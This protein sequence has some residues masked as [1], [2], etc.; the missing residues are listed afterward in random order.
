MTGVTR[1]KFYPEYG[2]AMHSRSARI[3]SLT[4]GSV[5]RIANQFALPFQA[6]SEHGKPSLSHMTHRLLCLLLVSLMLANQGLCLAHSHHG[7]GVAVPKDHA[8]RPHFHVGDHDHHDHHDSTHGQDQQS[9]HSHG[10]QSDRDCP[11]DEQDTALPKAMAPI[12]EHD[13]D[14]V[15]CTSSVPV[16]RNGNS[17][18]VLSAKDVVLAPIFHVA[19]QGNRSFCA[20][21]IRGQPPSVFETACPIYLRTL[22]LRI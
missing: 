18:N 16:A 11:L 19:S 10:N 17:V 22:S 2:F 12:G 9:D 5:V 14:A 4:L 21:P 3:K 1:T 7:T 20:G 8:S 13:S 15:Y 6:S